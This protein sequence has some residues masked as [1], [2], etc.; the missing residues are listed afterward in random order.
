MAT[1][2]LAILFVAAA[3]SVGT[4]P[5]RVVTT[6]QLPCRPHMVVTLS[7]GIASRTMQGVV[8]VGGEQIPVPGVMVAVRPLGG[9]SAIA[10][11]TTDANGAFSIP[12]V[13]DGWYQLETCH[14][15]LQSSVLPVRISKHAHQDKIE[16][17]VHLAV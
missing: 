15:G 2:R 11:V 14:E 6:H 3:C 12:S 16:V 7:K 9:G 10:V 17:T 4:R 5:P 8:R 13:P 1:R